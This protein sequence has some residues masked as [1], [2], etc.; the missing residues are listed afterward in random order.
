MKE[1]HIAPF[2][3]PPKMPLTTETHQVGKSL[4]PAVLRGLEP[5]FTPAST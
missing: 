3:Q 2:H 4:R 5:C 1:L